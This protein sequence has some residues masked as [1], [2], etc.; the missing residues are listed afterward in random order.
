MNR[1][2][3]IIVF[4]FRGR[5]YHVR[6]S[7]RTE[8][9]NT[10]DINIYEEIVGFTEVFDVTGVG[11][12]EGVVVIGIDTIVVVAVELINAVVVDVNGMI[13]VI[14]VDGMIVV[15]DVDEMIVVVIDVEFG[16]VV[17]FVVV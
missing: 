6:L 17:L 12:A 5:E 8:C 4:L 15:V 2:V 1:R 7:V 9:N 16:V 11:D 3:I 10:H 13:V 14:E